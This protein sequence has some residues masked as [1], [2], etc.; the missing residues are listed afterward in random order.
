MA[1]EKKATGANT[2][3]E[4]SV[5]EATTESVKTSGEN[6]STTQQSPSTFTAVN[7]I[8]RVPT[9][10]EV[11]KSLDLIGMVNPNN[12]TNKTITWSII[13]QGGTDASLSNNKLTAKIAGTVKIRATVAKGKTESTPYTQDFKITITEPS[14]AFIKVESITSV[15]TT[16]EVDQ[17][18]KLTGTVNPP[19]ATYQDITWS[20]K[21]K[22]ETDA[23]LSDDN[24]LTAKTAGTVKI[25]ATV[26]KGKTE[27]TPYTQDFK[28]TITQSQPAFIKVESIRL[29]SATSIEVGQ[30]LNLMGTVNPTNATYGD[31]EW[32]IAPHGRTGATL[33][34]NKLIAKTA[35]TVT[36]TATIT[37]G[38]ETQDYTQSFSIKI[39]KPLKSPISIPMIAST[40]AVLLAL[41]SFILTLVK[42]PNNKSIKEMEDK[43]Q[44]T[45]KTLKA[46]I[47]DALSQRSGNQDEIATRKL[48]EQIQ[49]SI[50]KIDKVESSVWGLDARVSSLERLKKLDT[51]S[52]QPASITPTAHLTPVDAVD[53]F[54]VWA[55]NPSTKLPSGFYY[56]SEDM[57]IRTIHSIT[58]SASETKWIS[59]KNGNQKYLFPNP[60][61]F[62]VNTD[63]NEFYKMDMAMLRS[64]GQNKIQI[65]TACEMSEKG[66][67]NYPGELKLL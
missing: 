45:E 26:A 11:G 59:N 60:N 52:S 34:N 61:F 20:I 21:S 49:A 67:I 9:T 44:D 41:L 5:S 63:I 50:G 3:S 22:G 17:S 51:S 57:R 19:N 24:K 31:I 62:N 38:E 56:L 10:I 14:S 39:T 1:A 15:P 27:S 25:R 65:T 46:K 18:L 35:G 48:S 64:K 23:S 42:S 47:N 16:V 66:Y 33:S 32:S 37:N 40:A 8:T 12:T 6:T 55:A 30:S 53:E 29:E 13:S 36:I 43:L 4:T 2:Q 54:N 58:E 7:N 28:I